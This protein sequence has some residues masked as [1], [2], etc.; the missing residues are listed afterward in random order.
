MIANYVPFIFGDNFLLKKIQE[1][2]YPRFWNIKFDCWIYS[3]MILTMTY[4][5]LPADT[6]FE[7]ILTARFR[8]EFHMLTVY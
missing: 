2:Y 8:D 3:N 5:I 6:V 1:P 7:L 4:N